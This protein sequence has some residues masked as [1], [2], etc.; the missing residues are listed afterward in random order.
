MIRIAM[1]SLSPSMAA[2][3]KRFLAWQE[4]H[5]LCLLVYKATESFPKHELYGLTSQSRRAAFSAPANIVEGASRKGKKEFRRYLDIA[6]G[7]LSELEYALEVAL[8]LGYVK[9][10]LYKELELQQ[11]R[12]RVFTW[13][14]KNSMR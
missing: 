14:L 7:S 13:R 9:P 5:K 4:C 8:A 11:R 10:E 12:A 3:H 2:P 1:G 6:L